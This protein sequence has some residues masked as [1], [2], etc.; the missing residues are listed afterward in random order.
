[1]KYRFIT[2]F[3]VAAL[4]F[5]TS[6][7]EWLNT[8]P[9]SSI[10]DQVALNDIAGVE[11]VIVGLYDV[12]QTVNFYG[13]DI[14]VAGEL[15][16]DN[17]K[18]ALSNSNRFPAHPVNGEGAGFGED[19]TVWTNA[20]RLINRVN[21]ILASVDN[22]SDGTQARIDQAK[23]EAHFIRGLAYFELLRIYARNP[24][25][26]VGQP[27]GVIHKLT[28]FVGIDANTFGAR[29]TIEAG[30]ELVEAD[31]LKAESF[32]G[33]KD[34][35]YRATKLAAQSM[36]AR[37]YLYWGKWGQARDYALTVKAARGPNWLTP[38]AQYRTVFSSSPGTES[39]FELRY[40]QSEIQNINTSLSGILVRTIGG[41]GY[42]DII[43]RTD[44]RNQFEP[45]DVRG[46]TAVGV[47]ANNMIQQFNKAG[48]TVFF[49][50]KWNGWKGQSYWDDV[51]IIR[52]SEIQLILAES[53][54]HPGP[55]QDLA[56]C[57]IAINDLRLARGLFSTTADDAGL[58]DAILKERRTELCFEGHRWFDLTRLGRDIPKPEVGTPLSWNDYRTVMRIPLGE[59]DNNPNLIQNPGY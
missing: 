48:E 37:L 12:L 4:I 56:L 13:R 50:L 23:G 20:Y 8:E 29:E 42:G 40:E 38:A 49:T 27:L 17:G 47:T 15:L 45:G 34:A 6:C 41:I 51:A 26:P 10:S 44:L 22:V 33:T 31:L 46:I 52:T 36:L 30:Y 11:A 54:F 35:P 39:I 58:L 3:A 9:R 5:A 59:R 1:M 18:I 24:R 57:R 14:F 19:I 55:A 16:A 28:P 32:L 7:N 43:F 2:I 21:L 25:F 53:Y